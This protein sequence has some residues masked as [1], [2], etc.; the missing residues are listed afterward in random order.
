M[1][2]Y[3]VTFVSRI[4]PPQILRTMIC[5]GPSSYMPH[6]HSIDGDMEDGV[7]TSHQRRARVNLNWTP[8]KTGLAF[9]YRG[10]TLMVMKQVSNKP[11]EE[12]LLTR[13]NH[14]IN[15]CLLVSK[16]R[17]EVHI[18]I[19]EWVSL[20]NKLLESN[21]H[22]FSM[23]R[24]PGLATKLLVILSTHVKELALKWF[25]GMICPNP[26]SETPFI[27]YIPCWNCCAEIKSPDPIN[28]GKYW[29]LACVV[30]IVIIILTPFSGV[31]ILV[32]ST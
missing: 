18:H 28:G 22:S 15:R 14:Q 2:T 27:T 24:I 32:S 12:F 16:Y 3:I 11:C 5:I 23:E 26:S 13:L 31:A 6:S 20:T 29:V 19:N 4:C 21:P 25:P 7:G 10:Q 1:C 8:W 30:Y 17:I 9:S